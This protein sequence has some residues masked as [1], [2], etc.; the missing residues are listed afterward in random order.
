MEKLMR[1]KRYVRSTTVTGDAVY[2]TSEH[3]R[4]VRLEGGLVEAMAPLLQG[5]HRRADIV[6]ELAEQFSS[7]RVERG[8][9]ILLAAGHVVESDPETNEREAGYWEL[10]GAQGD[11][12]ART[13]RDATV[14]LMTVGDVQA[15][16]FAEAAAEFGITVG[17][18]ESAA[19]T[20]VLTDDYLR[21]ELTAINRQLMDEGRPWLLV[22]P[23]GCVL[24]VGPV[25]DAATTACYQCL[26]VRL[27]H[28]H[29]LQSYLHQR[30][31][32]QEVLVHSVADVPSTVKIA[33]RI[34]ALETAK[35][36]AGIP[37]PSTSQVIS[38]DTATLELDHHRVVRRS[39]CPACGDPDL[40]AARQRSPL[41]LVSRPKATTADGGHRA[42]H[43][44]QFL[45][46][47]QHLISPISGP[48]SRLTKVP[49]EVEGL[50]TYTADQNFAMP[51]ANAADLRAGLRSR[52]AGKGIS[53][54]QARASAL[55][56][57]IE[58]YSGV[59]HGDEARIVNSYKALGPDLAIDPNAIH[60]YSEQQFA[61]RAEWNTRSSHFH[62]VS[63][64]MDPERRLEWSPVWSLTEQR[65][66]YLPTSCLYFAYTSKDMPFH[67]GANSNGCAAGTS[68]EDAILQGFFELV[69]R[70]TVAMW[71][72][73]RLRRP[74][75]DLDSFD[76]PYFARWQDRYRSLNRATWV[77]DVTNDLGIPSVVA[78]S[79]R[80]DK[81][82][83]DI[84]FALGCHF[85]IRV[86]IGRA[87]SEMNQFLP[88]VIGMRADGTGRYAYNDPDQ[89]DWWRTATV[90]SQPYLLP[91]ESSARTVD[92]YPDVATDDLLHDV[93]RA[94]QI[95]ESKGME[96]LVLDQTRVD[97]GLPVARVI[98][99][100]MRHFWPR[101]APGRLFDVP[102]DMGWLD[103][104]ATERDLNP[105]AMF[106]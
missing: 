97:I 92:D 29:T 105:I 66:K 19:L 71:W 3:L 37:G 42:T 80:M 30:G 6:G 98:V 45:D 67:A 17:E 104:P 84:L 26:R 53:D 54:L 18:A 56:E 52:S 89:L 14:H 2:L 46:T 8:L 7:Q 43:P 79:Y 95:V 100:G 39:Q 65:H 57:A 40:Q 96:M 24:W 35:M 81:P 72:Y 5:R 13:I 34:A 22:K 86:A 83:Q 88:A 69:E 16:W 44:Q 99:P 20:V 23:V 12:A 47:F 9:D 76:D 68:L 51:M 25:F 31:A 90:K 55:G 38:L 101:Y 59:F 63:D 70:D 78:V 75:I 58:R 93:H 32:L 1:F 49:L 27:A 73:H 50:H 85:D 103:Q 87:L 36:L 77:L 41:K 62:W 48:V 4:Q 94:Q 21:P 82:A 74:R 61:D 91:D 28:K 33:T 15:H 106:L 60:L 10:L 102:L 11:E 64:K